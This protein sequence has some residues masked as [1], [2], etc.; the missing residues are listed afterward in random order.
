MS[1]LFRVCCKDDQ[2][3][4][5]RR[6]DG[7]KHDE[8]TLRKE[9]QRGSDP[10]LQLMLNICTSCIQRLCPIQPDF[11]VEATACTQSQRTAGK[12][13]RK[14]ED[15]R[16]NKNQFCCFRSTRVVGV[17]PFQGGAFSATS[18]SM[19]PPSQTPTASLSRVAHAQ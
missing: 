11:T 1:C 14:A 5:F 8:E 13:R 9:T 3:P 2:I 4:P 19:M 15:Q 16:R 7:L 10:E 6:R 18:G 12:R 17:D